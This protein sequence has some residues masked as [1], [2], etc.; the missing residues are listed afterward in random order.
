[1]LKAIWQKF[2][3][4]WGWNLARL[5]AYTCIMGLF[6]VL[7]LELVLLSLFLRIT[8]DST[9]Q[10]AV[11]AIVR[12][13][14]DRVTAAA[15][16]SFADTIEHAPFVLVLLGLPITL[17]YGT[18]FFVVIETCLCVI[19]RRQQRRFL[20]QNR[21]ALLMLLLFAAALPTMILSAT[22][23]PV[24]NVGLGHSVIPHTRLAN[25]PLIAAIALFTS[26]ALNFLLLLTLYSV[27]TPGGVSMRHT[28]LGAL[29]G[30]VL[31]QGYILI[32][33]V[34]TREVLQP[35]HFGTVAGFVFVVLIFFYA[36]SLFVIC[37]AELSSW[38]AGYRAAPRSITD[39]LAYAHPAI[40]FPI[41]AASPGSLLEWLGQLRT[42]YAPKPAEPPVKPAAYVLPADDP[43]DLVAD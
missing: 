1:M 24:V 16:S 19:F 31:A 40:L 5:L 43:V 12:L 8:S 27:V 11:T 41:R 35:Q 2:D 33:P 38:R 25:E 22:F 7:G 15:V 14:P 29:L 37:G 21:V 18:R 4:D 42:R 17:W 34:Y 13:L 6:S 36:Y 39:T 28:W 9:E 30:A 20:D 23:T 10:E 26:L 32:F 3:R